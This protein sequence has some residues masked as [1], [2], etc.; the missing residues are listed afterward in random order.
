MPCAFAHQSCGC[1]V[2]HLE[3]C[4]SW[5]RQQAAPSAAAAAAAVFLFCILMFF[6]S[7]SM[8]LDIWGI[9]GTKRSL[10]LSAGVLSCT[11]TS[12]RVT[13]WGTCM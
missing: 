7:G 5:R 4:G 12:K 8:F 13:G 6:T 1:G 10:G 11:A 2:P 3:G 9:A